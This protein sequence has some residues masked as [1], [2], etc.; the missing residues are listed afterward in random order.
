MFITMLHIWI[1]HRLADELTLG[2][3]FGVVV[4]GSDRSEHDPS[5]GYIMAYFTIKRL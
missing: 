4:T 1:L 3:S 2:N 5:S